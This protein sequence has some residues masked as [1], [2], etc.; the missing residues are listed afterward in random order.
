VVTGQGERAFCAGSDIDEMLTFDAVAMH[1]ML[2]AERAMYLAA[3][4]ATKPVVGAVNGHALGAGMILVMSCDYAVASSSA[5]FGTPELTIGVAAPLEGFLLPWIV[6]LGRARAMF[7]TGRRMDAEEAVQ[8]G[9]VHEV[10]EPMAC[11]SRAIEAAHEIASL[12]SNAFSIQKS[13]LRRLIYSGDLET[14]IDASHHATSLQFARRETS[15][16]LG[17]F[18]TARR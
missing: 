16:A 13:L 14:V 7:F 2:E 1:R 12:P 5:S 9:L 18:L 3:L 11:V 4:E 8:V 15:E 17:R 10:T 6:G